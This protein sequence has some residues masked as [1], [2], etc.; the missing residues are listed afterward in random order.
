[1][2]YE[3]II[4]KII[5]GSIDIGLK[6]LVAIIVLAIGLRVI[7]WIEKL[8][9]KC[10]YLITNKGPLVK[11]L[12]HRPLKATFMGSNPIWVTII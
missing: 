1:M 11:W 12:T 8:I 4:E 2:K 3:E 5:S 7:K 10:Y 6:I 9:K